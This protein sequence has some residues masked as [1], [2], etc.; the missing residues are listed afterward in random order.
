MDRRQVTEPLPPRL[1]LQVVNLDQDQTLL[2][3]TTTVPTSATHPEAEVAE[4]TTSS[5]RRLRITTAAVQD[6]PGAPGFGQA[7]EALLLNGRIRFMQF[8]VRDINKRL[9]QLPPL[10]MPPPWQLLQPNMSIV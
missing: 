6:H 10:P 2:P 9:L 1:P 7:K 8:C 5:P 4:I 3:A